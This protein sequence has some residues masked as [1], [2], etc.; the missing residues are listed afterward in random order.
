MRL[1]FADF[2]LDTQ[3]FTLRQR[4]ELRKI[5][6][7]VFNLL[8]YLARHQGQVVTRQELLDTLWPGKVISDSTL[9][10][11]IKAARRAL[12]DTGTEQTFI[13]TCHR[14]GY[15]FLVAVESCE[16]PTL[17]E[18]SMLHVRSAS[19]VSEAIETA[20]RRASIAV[21]PFADIS[22]V[23]AARGG[24]ADALAHDV[25]TR[26]AQLRSLF[27]IAQ[28]TMFALSERLLSPPEAGR[29]LNVDYL[30]SGTVRRHNQRI[31]VTCELVETNSGRIVWADIL[32]RQLDDTFLVLDQIGQ[33]IVAIAASEIELAERNRAMLQPPNSLDAWEAH[34]RGLWHMYRFNKEDNAQA[35]HFFEMAVRLDP[36]FAHAYAGLSFTHFQNAFQGWADH[37]A[38]TE[39]AF[40]TANRSLEIDHRNPIAHW[41]VGRAFWLRGETERSIAELEQS[42]QLSPSFAL[43]HYAL[44]FVHAQSGDP[45]TAIS[46]ADH[47]RQLSPFDPLLFGMLGARALALA[48]LGQYQDAAAW[49]IQAA[50]R[51][52]AH[53]HIFSIAS[54]CLELAGS[55][56]AARA[57]LSSIRKLRTDYRIADFL[58]AFQFDVPTAAVFRRAAQQ[59]GMV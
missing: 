33:Q 47:S 53:V 12:G 18:E 49:A 13:E 46:S 23:P 32:D 27:V 22:L 50:D 37:G 20:P 31:V 38:E 55:H 48:R 9:G 36:N 19:A 58:S 17:R 1:S 21:M 8:A 45:S 44:A 24:V 42:T 40:E 29:L 30:V 56:D 3:Q 35:R 51:P 2:E 5:Q 14:R 39:R 59:I 16:F 28:G 34:H 52:N 25:I 7:L 57:Y 41:A 26:L 11:C 4:G 43:G 6:P 54:L 15:R 10:T